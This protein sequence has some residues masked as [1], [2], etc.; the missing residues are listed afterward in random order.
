MVYLKYGSNDVTIVN[1]VLE[2]RCFF[3]IE[4]TDWDD[5][6]LILEK[7]IRSIFFTEKVYPDL[8]G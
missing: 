6:Y 2:V 8:S 7:E 5:S 3:R 1:R 4:I